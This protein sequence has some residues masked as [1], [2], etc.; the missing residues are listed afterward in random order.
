MCAVSSTRS[1]SHRVSSLIYYSRHQVE[2]VHDLVLSDVTLER[3]FHSHNLIRDSYSF[4]KLIE[5]NISDYFAMISNSVLSLR[6]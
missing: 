3:L 4:K 1:P 5:S 2:T 6:A